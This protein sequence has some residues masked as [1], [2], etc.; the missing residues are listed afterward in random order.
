NGPAVLA[1]G[2]WSFI[3][4]QLAAHTIPYI[5]NYAVQDA[6]V[7]ACGMVGIIDNENYVALQKTIEEALGK[8]GQKLAFNEGIKL[9]DSDFSSVSTKVVSNSAIDCLFISAPAPQAANLV[10]Q[11]RSA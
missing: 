7:K 1:A 3:T 8:A 9:A 11:L 2:P 10:I 5:A 4:T 6:K